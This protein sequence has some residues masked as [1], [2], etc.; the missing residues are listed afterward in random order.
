MT[1][2]KK[3]QLITFVASIY[4]LP[5][6]GLALG[7]MWSDLKPRSYNVGDKLDIH[8]GQLWSFTNSPVPYDYYSLN[9]CDSKAGHTY[10]NTHLT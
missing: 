1:R 8:V 7:R 5:K 4:F 9:W 6:E 10:D 3:L 2:P